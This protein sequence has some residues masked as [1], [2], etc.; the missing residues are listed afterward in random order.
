MSSPPTIPP[1]VAASIAQIVPSGQ[2]WSLYW[3]SQYEQLPQGGSGTIESLDHQLTVPAGYSNDLFA[4]V[5]A[6]Q[7]IATV[8][9]AAHQA[10]KTPYW[11]G[12]YTQPPSGGVVVY[13]TV[14]VTD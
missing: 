11:I 3:A 1:A 5:S 12:V 7:I 13:R 8:L 4:Y 10:G 9:Q 2:G 6:D 14:W